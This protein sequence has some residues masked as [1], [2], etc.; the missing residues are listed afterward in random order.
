MGK[1]KYALLGNFHPYFV[2]SA[3]CCVLRAVCKYELA[4]SVECREVSNLK[5]ALLDF[6]KQYTSKLKEQ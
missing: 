6:Q 2:L 4:L 3:A 5:Q 1:L